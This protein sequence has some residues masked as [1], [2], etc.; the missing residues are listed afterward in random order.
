MNKYIKIKQTVTFNSLV[1]YKC[2][3]I[4][5]LLVGLHVSINHCTCFHFFYF[6]KKWG[7]AQDFWTVMW[8]SKGQMCY[9]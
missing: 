9:H 7:V 6:R 1:L 4:Y 8:D 5:A 2:F 3:A